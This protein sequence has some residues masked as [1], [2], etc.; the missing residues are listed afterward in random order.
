MKL[1]QFEGVY[2]YFSLSLRKFGQNRGELTTLFV[3]FYKN[4]QKIT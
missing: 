3:F 2:Y 4:V 1:G